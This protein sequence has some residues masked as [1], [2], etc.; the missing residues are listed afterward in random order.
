VPTSSI[1]PPIDTKRARPPPPAPKPPLLG[2][3]GLSTQPEEISESEDETVHPSTA[4]T[5]TIGIAHIV[6]DTRLSNE[7]KAFGVHEFVKRHQRTL[8]HLKAMEARVT[9]EIKVAEA[10]LTASPSSV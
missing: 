9:R 4:A 10:Y 6:Q 1:L 7:E 3:D 8:R 2:G 5:N